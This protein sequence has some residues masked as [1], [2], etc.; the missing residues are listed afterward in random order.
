MATSIVT[1]YKTPWQIQMGKS[2]VPF[3]IETWSM[4]HM[5]VFESSLQSSFK[6]MSMTTSMATIIFAVNIPQHLPI[7][8]NMLTSWRSK[9]DIAPAVALALLLLFASQAGKG[10]TLFPLPKMPIAPLK[11]KWFFIQRCLFQKVYGSA[12]RTFEWRLRN[13]VQKCVSQVWVCLWIFCRFSWWVS[14]LL[15]LCLQFYLLA[16]K[17]LCFS[18]LHRAYV[19]HRERSFVCGP[20]TEN[21]VHDFSVVDLTCRHVTCLLLLILTKGLHIKSSS[22][23]ANRFSSWPELTNCF[24][25]SFHHALSVTGNCSLIHRH[26]P[27]CSWLI[28]LAFEKTEKEIR[29]RTWKW[30]EKSKSCCK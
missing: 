9:G 26:G 7:N 14:C 22:I 18:L 28:F 3:V 20:L 4:A 8:K 23:P 21:F 16:P 29:A 2:Q 5:K 13:I 17:H 25:C 12:W 19:R 11:P 6:R 10:Q 30:F 15:G 24:E 1:R 27:L